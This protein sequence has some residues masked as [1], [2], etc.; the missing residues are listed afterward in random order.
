[1]KPMTTYTLNNRLFTALHSLEEELTLSETDNVIFDLSHLGMLTVKGDAAQQF[2]QGQVTCQVNDV[3]PTSMR[4]SALCN[5]QGRILNLLDIIQW[6][7]YHLVMPND[8]LDITQASLAKV[9]LLSRVAIQK[10]DD[11]VALGLYLKHPMPSFPVP[12]PLAP[13]QAQHT[14]EYYCYAISEHLH[15]L[16]LP[17]EE[18][19]AIRSNYV[20][21]A[22]LFILI[23]EACFFLID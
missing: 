14:S 11:R 18:K 20:N 3:T 17:A 16:L 2:L 5:L 4:P 12:L 9:A 21:N 6:Q 8:L 15:I 1:M 22:Y 10:R 23:H 7:E 13:W 19:S